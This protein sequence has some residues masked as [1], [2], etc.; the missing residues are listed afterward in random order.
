MDCAVASCLA[1]LHAGRALRE[2]IFKDEY[3]WG[4]RIQSEGAV[5]ALER[6]LAHGAASDEALAQFQASLQ[7]DIRSAGWVR[8]IRMERAF[9][10]AVFTGARLGKTPVAE[11]EKNLASKSG[12]VSN[13]LRNRVPGF[14]LSSYPADLKHTTRLVEIA[15]LPPAEQK[16]KI[17]EWEEASRKFPDLRPGLF[18]LMLHRTYKTF[19]T[20]QGTLRAAM[21]ALACERYRVRRGRWPDSLDALVQEGLLGAVPTDPIDLQ[22]LRYRPTPDGIV[23]Y[24]IGLDGNDDGGH[25]ARDTGGPGTDNGFRLYEVTRRRLQPA[26]VPEDGP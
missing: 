8:P 26:A 16:R 17:Q 21:A 4:S 23:I 2:G 1:V 24:S 9:W 15:K 25:I 20:D 12:G 6:V 10:H 3:L 19:C 14:I 13:W 22:P 7:L 11:V 5:A 18:R